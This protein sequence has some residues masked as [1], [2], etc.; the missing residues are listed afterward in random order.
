MRA[1]SLALMLCACTEANALEQQAISLTPRSF[2]IPIWSW[3]FPVGLTPET[4]HY[5]PYSLPPKE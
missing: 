1:L 4:P 2:V 5:F 3:R